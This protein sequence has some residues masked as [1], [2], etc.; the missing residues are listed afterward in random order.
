MCEKSLKNSG[1][2]KQIKNGCDNKQNRYTNQ[3]KL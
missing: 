3:N 2:Y 1:E